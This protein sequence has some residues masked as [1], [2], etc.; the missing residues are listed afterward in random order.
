MHIESHAIG[1][2]QVSQDT[3]AFQDAK[4]ALY[5]L[6]EV[7]TFIYSYEYNTDQ[8]H[9][10]SLV[11]GEHSSYRVSS[12]TFKGCCC[13]SE[14]P[15]GSLLITGGEDEAYRVVREVVRINTRREFAV[16][17]CAP[18][19]TPRRM[20]AAVYHTP[21]LCILGGSNDDICLSECERY[22]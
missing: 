13:W 6:Y 7:P 21:H 8:L 11:T 18:I 16:A 3:L 19:L 9:R 14:V 2:E 4:E 22:V 15:E 20:H 5:H 10:T 17:H 12:Y 1:A